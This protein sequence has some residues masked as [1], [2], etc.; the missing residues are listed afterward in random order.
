MFVVLRY[1]KA[2]KDNRSLI[3]AFASGD[4]KNRYRNSVLGFFWSILEPLL[5]LTVLYVVF[6][7][8]L[9][10]GIPNFA[11]YL[12]LGLIVWNFISKSTTMGLNSISNKGTIITNVYFQRAIPALSSNIT[13]LFMLSLEFIIFAAFF[14]AFNATVYPTMVFLPYLVFLIFM[15]SLGLS[16]PLSVLSVLY[17]DVQFIWNIVLSVGFFVHPIIYN[18]GI[19]PNGIRETFGFI[20]TVR[21]FNMIHDSVLSGKTPSVIDFVYVTACAFT[22]LSLG[23]LVYRMFEPKV[24]EEI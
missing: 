5:L 16:L 1:F 10:P 12:L 15:I 22:I 2:L 24:A 7:S 23:Y 6:S 19:L 4:L 9:K 21:I 14:I 13:G 3:L 17:K 18:T 20:P 11:I 8:L